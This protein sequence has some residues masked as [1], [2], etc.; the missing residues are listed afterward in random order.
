MNPAIKTFSPAVKSGGNL[1]DPRRIRLDA[2]ILERSRTLEVIR[3]DV[4]QNRIVFE[5]PDGFAVIPFIDECRI[6]EDIKNFDLMFDITM[7]KLSGKHVVIK[8]KAMD[9]TESIV[10]NFIVTNRYMDMHGVDFINKYPIVMTWLMEF[11]QELL[12][13]KFPLPPETWGTGRE[14]QANP[15]TPK[16]E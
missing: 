9:G 6:L 14:R 3:E 15:S 10:S 13:K 12:L 4:K 2:E 7:Q 1:S 11:M 8:L 5:F 16:N